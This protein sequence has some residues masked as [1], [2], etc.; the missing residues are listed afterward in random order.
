MYLDVFYLEIY[1]YLNKV[2]TFILN[3][4]SVRASPPA[5]PNRRLGTAVWGRRQS[6]LYLGMLLP[7]WRP[8]TGGLDRF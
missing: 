4:E 2:E 8:Q 7:R 6:I 1:L 5:A 3:G